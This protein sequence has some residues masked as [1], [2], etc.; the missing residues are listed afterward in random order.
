M[1]YDLDSPVPLIADMSSDIFSRPVDVSK[2]NCIFYAGAQKNV[3][4]AGVN[5]VIVKDEALNKVSRQIPTML[6]YMTH[7]KNGSM[8]NTPQWYPSTVP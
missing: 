6:D 3:S 1:R 5:I 4:M 8:F 7:V 2:Y